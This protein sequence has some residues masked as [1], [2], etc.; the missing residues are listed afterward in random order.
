MSRWDST[1]LARLESPLL[2]LRAVRRKKERFD[3]WQRTYRGMPSPFSNIDT[4]YV[5]SESISGLSRY[6][7]FSFKESRVQGEVVQ[8]PERF[9]RAVF[10]AGI[11]VY[12]DISG[13]PNVYRPT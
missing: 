11:Q 12:A 1:F 6:A 2:A 8:R 4:I 7:K 3:E 10:G 13:L 9:A 5:L